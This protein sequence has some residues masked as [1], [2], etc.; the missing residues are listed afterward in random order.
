MWG[1]VKEKQY[2][3]S[4]TDIQVTHQNNSTSVTVNQD[5]YVEM[6]GDIDIDPDRLHQEDA[7]LTVNEIAACNS[8]PSPVACCANSTSAVCALQPLTSELHVSCT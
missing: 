7:M 2:G 8:R 5:H 1:T 3:H 4:G 6:V